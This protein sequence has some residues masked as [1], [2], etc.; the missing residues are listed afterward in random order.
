MVNV[1]ATRNSAKVTLRKVAIAMDITRTNRRRMLTRCGHCLLVPGQ[2]L[3]SIRCEMVTIRSTPS[4]PIRVYANGLSLISR[5]R[6]LILPLL[7]VL[8]TFPS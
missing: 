7:L 4:C 2:L 1:G 3:A 8:I 6:V 5:Q